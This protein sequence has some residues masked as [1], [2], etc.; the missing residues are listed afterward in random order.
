VGQ[1]NR[2]HRCL[3][4]LEALIVLNELHEKMV[5]RHFAPNITAKKNWMQDIVG[6][7]NSR[8]LMIFTKVVTI[9][10]KLGD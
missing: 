3:T 5:G 10:K 1:N 8:I 2:M 9:I 6:Q 4:T 7:L